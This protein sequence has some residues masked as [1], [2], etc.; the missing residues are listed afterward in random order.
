MGM[1]GS[2][3]ALGRQGLHPLG[4]VA[5]GMIL[6]LCHLQTAFGF[7]WYLKIAETWSFHCRFLGHNRSSS[8]CAKCWKAPAP[9][10]L[11][12]F[13]SSVKT[14]Q[15]PCQPPHAELNRIFLSLLCTFVATVSEIPVGWQVA[16]P[17]LNKILH[18]LK[19]L[20]GCNVSR[21]HNKAQGVTF[22]T[23]S[24]H[25]PKSFEDV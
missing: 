17:H 22:C 24:S 3:R 19:D 7:F 12:A 8:K 15:T 25:N 23:P 20:C 16:E 5:D 10:L 1:D 4:A 6:K 9:S 18:R 11:G 14:R 2:C 13:V 21:A